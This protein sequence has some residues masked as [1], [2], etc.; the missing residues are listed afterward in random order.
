MQILLKR[1]KVPFH[2]ACP[3]NNDMIGACDAMGW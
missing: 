2:A 1:G 3:A